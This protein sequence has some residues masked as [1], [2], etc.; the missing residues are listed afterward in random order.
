MV[1]RQRGA[2]ETPPFAIAAGPDVLGIG[3]DLAEHERP[4]HADA[5]HRAA[6]Q[7]GEE[8]RQGEPGR[9]FDDMREPVAA[10]GDGLEHELHDASISGA[11]AAQLDLRQSSAALRMA[12]ERPRTAIR[13]QR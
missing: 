7:P 9:R 10:R 8:Q 13:R 2:R 1:G 11:I 12:Q 5:M 4:A 6:A 3:H